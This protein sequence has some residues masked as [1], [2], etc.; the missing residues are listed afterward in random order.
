[1]RVLVTGGC[2]FIASHFINMLVENGHY[3]INVDRMDYCSNINNIKVPCESFKYDIADHEKIMKILRDHNINTVIHFAAQTHVDN[4]FDNSMSFTRDNVLGT[5]SLLETCR[6]YG[7]ITRFV[8]I[9]T[10]EV[11]GETHNTVTEDEILNPTNPYAASKAAAEFIVKSYWH[12]FKFP[13][14]ICRMNNVY[15]DNQYPEKVI[16]KFI[17]SMKNG[18]KCTIHGNGTSKRSFIHVHD[19]CTGILTVTEKGKISEVYNIGTDNE[20]VIIDLAEK[21]VQ[22]CTGSSN[23]QEWIEFVGDR[24]YNDYRYSINSNK[25]KSLG[26]S[27]SKVFEEELVRLCKCSQT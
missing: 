16:P 7:F 17:E 9:S 25:I 3:V 15:G 6:M 12:S 18:G 26:W 23:F 19:V 2:G 5:H 13:I 4:S 24:P 11:Y 21:I 22:I 10:D 8:H 1:M 27:E 14:L 20:I